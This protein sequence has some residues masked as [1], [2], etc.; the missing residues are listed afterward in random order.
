MGNKRYQVR[1]SATAFPDVVFILY[2]QCR[3]VAACMTTVSCPNAA[4]GI[5]SDLAIA[6]PGG[7]VSNLVAKRSESYVDGVPKWRQL[8][9]LVWYVRLSFM[10]WFGRAFACVPHRG[11]STSGV[12]RL[13]CA[14]REC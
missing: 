12:I 9:M 3:K 10:S 6:V 1:F 2:W 5:R 13:A 11:V 4:F 7:S 14:G 8:I